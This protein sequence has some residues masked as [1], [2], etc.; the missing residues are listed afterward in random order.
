M[1]TNL[2]TQFQDNPVWNYVKDQL[3]QQQMASLGLIAI[4]LKAAN[5]FASDPKKHA[6]DLVKRGPAA[7]EAV[8]CFFTD[9]V[10][11]G[12]RVRSAKAGSAKAE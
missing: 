7:W 11:E 12:R 10:E 2:M 6:N 1:A 4:I 9:L 3:R 5:D 8:N